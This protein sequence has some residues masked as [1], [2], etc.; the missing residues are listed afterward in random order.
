MWLQVAELTADIVQVIDYG[1]H[2]SG[3]GIVCHDRTPSESLDVI[4]AILKE[5][6]YVN[7]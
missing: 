6:E 2:F 1:E 3:H 7:N 5:G 4:D